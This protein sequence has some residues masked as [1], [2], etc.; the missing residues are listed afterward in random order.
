MAKEERCSNILSKLFV[1]DII[2]LLVMQHDK[3]IAVQLVI[4]ARARVLFLSS[5]SLT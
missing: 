1:V 3:N 2:L 5:L 4:L